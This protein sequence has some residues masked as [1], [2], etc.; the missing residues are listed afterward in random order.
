MLAFQCAKPRVTPQALD[1][2]EQRLARLVDAGE[3]HDT[4]RFLELDLEFHEACWKVSGSCYMIDLLRR[5]MTPLSVFVVLGSGIQ[6]DAVM[7]REHY[8]L[9]GRSAA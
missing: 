3:R 4:R 2:L 6:P 9:V 1:D 7:A 5:H 8:P